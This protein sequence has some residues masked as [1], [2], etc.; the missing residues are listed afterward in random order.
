MRLEADGQISMVKQNERYTV[1]AGCY[2]IRNPGRWRGWGFVWLVA[3]L[4]QHNFQ[5]AI[6]AFG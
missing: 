5:P 3:S 2:S 4:S 6:A 1:R